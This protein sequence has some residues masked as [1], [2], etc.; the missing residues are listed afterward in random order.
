MT[1]PHTLP[2]IVARM[3]EGTR[4]IESYFGSLP[5]AAFL[6]GDNAKWGPAH[7]LSHLSLANKRVARA[8]GAPEALPA[9]PT[10]V[11][12]P[13]DEIRR[14]YEEGLPRV[15]RERLLSNPVSPRVEPGATQAGV[16]AEYVTEAAALRA[17]ADALPEPEADARAVPHPFMGALTAREM[18][19]F[20][21]IHDRHHLEGVRR[22][23]GP[24]AA[25]R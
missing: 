21:A 9:H 16:I 18:L 1:G 7:H 23:F 13:Y 4:A 20:M 14:L 12:R 2:E 19:C 11:S 25:Q 10:G 5:E 3:E 6:A 15:P 24:D 22:R 17:A 8:L